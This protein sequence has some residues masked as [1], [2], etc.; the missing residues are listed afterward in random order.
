[1]TTPSPE[2]KPDAFWHGKPDARVRRR[3]IRD[4]ERQTR[5]EQKLHR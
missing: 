2:I 5:I 3:K 4:F 1:M